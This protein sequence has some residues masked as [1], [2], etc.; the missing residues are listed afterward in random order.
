M[1]PDPLLDKGI[2]HVDQ[3][4]LFGLHNTICD[5]HDADDVP[6]MLVND[7]RFQMYQCFG[8]HMRS[9]LQHDYIKVC[10][11]LLCKH[12]T[13]AFWTVHDEECHCDGARAQDLTEETSTANVPEE[14]DIGWIS[15]P[16]FEIDLSVYE[17]SEV[18]L[19]PVVYY[20]RLGNIQ[21]VLRR[22]AGLLL[23]D[24]PP[25]RRRDDDDDKA[26]EN[27]PAQAEESSVW[28][29]VT[30]KRNRKR[31][32][33]GKKQEHSPRNQ[34]NQPTRKH[35]PQRIMRQGHQPVGYNI[36]KAPAKHSTTCVVQRIDT[37]HELLNLKSDRISLRTR[38]LTDT[39]QRQAMSTGS[40]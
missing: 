6:W 19:R 36:T 20:P 8:I 18:Y 17:D 25:P 2:T 3:N 22:P 38:S 13:R 14:T 15:L 33:S 4:L 29:V 40:F 31:S 39:R 5:Y 24:F 10:W 11:R 30:N 37:V 9:E 34:V 23:P 27:I 26:D 32:P 7:I 1:K 28:V 12:A 16:I 35:R 21:E